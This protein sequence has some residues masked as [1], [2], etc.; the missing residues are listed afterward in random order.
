MRRL[1]HKTRR[2]FGQGLGCALGMAG[3]PRTVRAHDRAHEVEV[4]IA[5]FAFDPTWIEILVGDSVIWINNDL[6]PH[7]ATAKD[8]AWD[9]G[10]IDRGDTRR[11]TFEAPGEHP[12]FCAFHPHM[13][14]SILVRSRSEG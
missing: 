5:H 6:A 12:Y 7:T 14:G 4:R 3:A 2:W 13:K 8:A 11:I 9:T 10:S 1:T